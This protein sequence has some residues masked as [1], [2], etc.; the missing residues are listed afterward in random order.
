MH[1]TSVQTHGVGSF[2][3]LLHTTT[4]PPGAAW[5]HT[6]GQGVVA[7]HF[8]HLLSLHSSYLEYCLHPC[9]HI[10]AQAHTDWHVFESRSAQAHLMPRSTFLI[11]PY[12]SQSHSYCM[13]RLKLAQLLPHLIFNSSTDT[14]LFSTWLTNL[15][16]HGGTTQGLPLYG[17]Q[18]CASSHFFQDNLASPQAFPQAITKIACTTS[19]RI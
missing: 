2:L 3:Q 14:D 10:A 16:L 8:I 12:S 11:T 15:P 9:Y 17:L 1:F 19:A 7:P 6:T 4:A 5:E 13:N 18:L